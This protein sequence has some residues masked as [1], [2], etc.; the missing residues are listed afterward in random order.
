MKKFIIYNK[1]GE[2][3]RTGLCQEETFRLQ[4]QDG[5]FVMEGSANALTQK[6]I[7][8]P[9]LAG[10]LVNKTPEEIE[11]D[12]P[13]PRRI[14]KAERPAFITNEQWQDVL[15]RLGKLEKLIRR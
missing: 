4:S 9:N 3:L 15:D 11:K 1:K 10:M 5:E 6:I 8:N 12:N 13:P 2:I 14:P 7:V